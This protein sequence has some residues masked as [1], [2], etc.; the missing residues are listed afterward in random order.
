MGRQRKGGLA[1]RSL[2]Q[3]AAPFSVIRFSPT[4]DLAKQ[5]ET[6]QADILL[7]QTAITYTWGL[8]AAL[9]IVHITRSTQRSCQHGFPLVHPR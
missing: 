3:N 7:A 2:E 5:P 6:A 9:V 4:R 8:D 1:I